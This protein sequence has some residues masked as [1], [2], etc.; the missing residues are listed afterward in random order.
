ML[1]YKKF[2]VLLFFN[3]QGTV[4][5]KILCG[6]AFSEHLDEVSALSG[7]SSVDGQN[8]SVVL[9]KSFLLVRAE[10]RQRTHTQLWGEDM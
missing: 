10:L 5:D 3:D 4:N 8:Y 2:L 9:S 7:F 1:K 6:R